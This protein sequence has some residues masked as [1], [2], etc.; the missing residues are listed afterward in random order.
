MPASLPSVTHQATWYESSHKVEWS[1][2]TT[3]WAWAQVM[4]ATVE[5]QPEGFSKLTLS[6]R[7]TYRASI[8]DK[9]RRQRL[10][11]TLVTALDNALAHPLTTPVEQHDRDEF[12][13]WTGTAWTFEPPPTPLPPAPAG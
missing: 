2:D 3:G 6:G 7:S 1:V 9:G 11:D 8:G 13:W 5:P 4:T 12:R 10:F